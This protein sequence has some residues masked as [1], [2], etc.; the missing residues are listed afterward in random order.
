MILTSARRGD[1]KQFRRR[2]QAGTAFCDAVG[3]HRRHPGADRRLVDLVT[4][5]PFADQRADFVGH[6]EYLEHAQPAAIAGA[7][8]ALAAAWRLKDFPGTEAELGEPRVLDNVGL[9]NRL[10]C[11]AALA[12]MPD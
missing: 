5:G 2:R 7:A 3:S 6:F 4:V 9:L 10:R 8:T 12:Q 11:L 1:A